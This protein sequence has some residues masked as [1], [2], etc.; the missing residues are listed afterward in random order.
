MRPVLECEA[1]VGG[2][3]FQ[4]EPTGPTRAVIRRCEVGAAQRRRSEL[5]PQREVDPIVAT[6]FDA[7]DLRL[8]R[9]S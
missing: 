3:F 9:A 1:L 4:S 8:Q 7:D 6:F 2:H 5:T